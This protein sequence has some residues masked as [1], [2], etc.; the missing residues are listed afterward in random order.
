MEGRGEAVSTFFWPRPVRTYVG[1]EVATGDAMARSRSSTTTPLE[2]LGRERPLRAWSARCCPAPGARCRPTPVPHPRATVPALSLLR[3]LVPAPRPRAIPASSLR[4]FPTP[5]MEALA[6]GGE[7]GEAIGG[8]RKA[9]IGE[10][11]ARGTG[12]RRLGFH[13]GRP[14]YTTV[15]KE[16]R[17][18]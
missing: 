4:L 12:E 5:A 18:V 2:R 11:R 14:F 7:R 6:V 17:T 8:E 16:Y 13:C 15:V 3:R 10:E 1:V 9:A